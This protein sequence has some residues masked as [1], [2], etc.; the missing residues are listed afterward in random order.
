MSIFKGRPRRAAS[1]E[2]LAPREKV[3]V[4]T[5]SFPAGARVRRH[6]A[7][8]LRARVA[9][10]AVRSAKQAGRED[11]R[12]SVR[13]KR[14]DERRGAAVHQVEEDDPEAADG[15]KGIDEENPTGA[16]K[17]RR[18]SRAR[19][20][21]AAE[22]VIVRRADPPPGSLPPKS[23][24]SSVPRR[25]SRCRGRRSCR[26][27]RREGPRASGRSRRETRR[28]D[29]V[30]EEC[31][32]EGGRAARSGAGAAGASPPRKKPAA[33]G[34]R[35]AA[36]ELAGDEDGRSGRRASFVG[37]GGR[38]WPP[39]RRR[40]TRK[41][42]RKGSGTARNP[43]QRRRTAPVVVWRADTWRETGR[44][45][46]SAN[47]RTAAARTARPSA[48]G[49]TPT[50]GPTRAAAPIP[51]T[52]LRE[53]W[54]KS[55][56]LRVGLPDDGSP[57]GQREG[58]DGK[59]H[60]EGDEESHGNGRPVFRKAPGPAGDESGRQSEE[61]GRE[62]SRPCQAR[63]AL[64]VSP[65]RPQDAGEDEER[66]DG[67]EGEAR[68]E[69][70]ESGADEAEHRGLPPPRGAAGA[71]LRRGV[72]CPTAPRTARPFPGRKTPRR[73][74]RLPRE[75]TGDG[76]RDDRVGGGKVR[77]PGRGGPVGEG[78]RLTAA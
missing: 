29:G 56:D 67:L 27:R 30:G 41:A 78:K 73:V 13:G 15:E 58:E 26:R 31:G 33:P 46:S 47:R 35:P 43:R 8:L 49:E 77:V 12:G 21:A 65:R 74:V 4:M 23:S 66:E 48:T 18:R 39:P 71:P 72:L 10:A 44:S 9:L 68:D 64:E 3:P 16:A 75:G 42:A 11:E 14:Q 24:R 54:T 52:T 53:G 36:S 22:I 51:A 60:E 38:P 40:R 19:R 5:E 59:R 20:M 28:E 76:G 2:R 17:R 55:K 37:S 61:V 34:R 6:R 1:P 50:R 70:R 63:P 57:D 45:V 69:N 62:S 25:R 32:R 7:G